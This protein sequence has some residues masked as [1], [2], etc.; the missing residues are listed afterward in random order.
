MSR[1]NRK[2]IEYSEKLFK[3]FKKWNRNFVKEFTA[4]VCFDLIKVEGG[5]SYTN[6]A[7]EVKI[8]K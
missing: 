2:F 5:I 8:S 6:I 3:E 7:S 4:Y 1:K